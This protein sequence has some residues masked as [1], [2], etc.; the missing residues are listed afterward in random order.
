MKHTLTLLT[1]LLL[2]PLVSLRAAD[3]VALRSGT[4][5]IG[6]LPYGLKNPPP[7]PG[8]LDGHMPELGPG[9]SGN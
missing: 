2:V 5:T 8:F 6:S 1:A 4:S 3:D 9:V 7:M